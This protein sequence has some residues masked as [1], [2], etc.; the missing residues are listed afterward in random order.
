MVEEARL[1][2]LKAE[3]K[4]EWEQLLAFQA[5]VKEQLGSLQEQLGKIMEF[6]Q[7]KTRPEKMILMGVSF[8][9]MVEGHQKIQVL[10]FWDELFIR[11][12]RTICHNA[13][14]RTLMIGYFVLRNILL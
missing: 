3:I 12:S 9:L 14:V 1:S 8:D 7:N 13:M 2:E 11:D 10:G 4:G 6:M 5:E